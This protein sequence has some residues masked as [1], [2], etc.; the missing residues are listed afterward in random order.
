VFAAL[1]DKCVPDLSA[2]F[3]HSERSPTD[4]TMLS[5]EELEAIA[6]GLHEDVPAPSHSDQ[7]AQPLAS[8]NAG[9]NPGS[10]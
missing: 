1:L 9:G 7:P 2:S 8:C 3:V 10:H 6:A 4:L 5:R